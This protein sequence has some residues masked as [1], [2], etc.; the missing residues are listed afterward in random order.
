MVVEGGKEEDVVL[1]SVFM[2]PSV[3]DCWALAVVGGGMVALVVV[4]VLVVCVEE[5]GG[6]AV[7]VDMV[8]G[9]EGTVSLCCAVCDVSAC[10]G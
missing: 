3:L 8:E 10:V 5:A 1:S 7:A 4:V 2:S 9:E 6:A